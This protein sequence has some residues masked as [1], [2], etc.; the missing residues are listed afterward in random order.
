[1]PID[2]HEIQA[3]FLHHV[4]QLQLYTESKLEFIWVKTPHTIEN[5]EK[6]MEEVTTLLK[7][8]GLSSFTF[9]IV[10]AFFPFDGILEYAASSQSDLVA[11]P[12]H[13]RRGLSHLLSGS[14]TEDTV[15]HID[16][17]VWT[18]KLDKEEESLSLQSVSSEDGFPSSA[19]MVIL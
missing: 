14:L 5:E 10:N 8:H 6:V 13:A 12:T 7:K 17:P 9:S 4:Q 15:N 18:F 19:S 11:M 16:I 3:T 2:L 1:V